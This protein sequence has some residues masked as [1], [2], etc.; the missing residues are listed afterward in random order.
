MS[1]PAVDPAALSSLL[2]GQRAAVESEGALLEQRH[3]LLDLDADSVW[4]LPG[5]IPA[6]PPREEEKAA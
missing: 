4:T 1:A 6:C 2:A 3:Q 5:C